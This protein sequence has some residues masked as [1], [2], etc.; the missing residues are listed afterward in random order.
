MNKWS[1]C[2]AA[3][4][5]ATM[6]A[7]SAMA[8]PKVAD[9]INVI[10]STPVTFMSDGIQLA[11]NLYLPPNA[12]KSK[13]Y[14]AIVVSH[15]WGGVKE[16]T[17]GLYAQQLAKEGFITLA[18]DAAYY[19]QSKGEPRDLESPAQRV[20]D[21]RNAVSYLASLPDVDKNAIGTFGICAGG[22]YT[23]HEAQDD[24]R[25]KAVAT[26]SAYDIGDAAR[27]GITGSEITAQQR[28]ATIKMV[29]EELNKIAQGQSPTRL[30]LLPSKSEWSDKT[31]AFTKEA[32]SYYKEPRGA[33][34]NARNKF[35]LYSLGLH[36]AY[37]PTEHVDKISP[38]AALFIAGD[39]AETLK[40][41]QKAFEVAHEPK[42]LLVIKGAHHFDLYDK[43]QYVRPIV[44][45]RADFY[46]TH[47]KR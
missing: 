25:V 41:S 33:H 2:L 6:L 24:H 12:E 20:A 36:M 1:H 23:F 30:D 46:H 21:I 4:V 27:N 11:G 44:K 16:Q 42:E 13:K 18:Y 17:S 32:Y 29:D 28:E 10:G 5:C 14:P 40:F 3:P 26:V 43:P 15:P 45:K 47:L 19:G 9:N 8:T 7:G 31:D 39:K 38:R 37:Y 35:L 34:P 22:G